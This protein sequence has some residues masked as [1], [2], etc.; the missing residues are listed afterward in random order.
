[1]NTTE[2]TT[3]QPTPERIEACRESWVAVAERM[4]WLAEWEANGKHITV[5]HDEAGNVLD[6]LYMNYP[7]EKDFIVL[8][9]E[10][11]EE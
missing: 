7:T 11:D 4:G 10:E 6:S 2:L 8:S 9:D 3:T 5:W 1:M